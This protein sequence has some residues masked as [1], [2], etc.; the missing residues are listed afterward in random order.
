MTKPLKLRAEGADD[1]A[2]ISAALQDAIARVGEIHFSPK[3]RTLTLRFTR[4]RHEDESASQRTLTGLR[5]D[6]ILSVQSSGIDRADPDAMAVLL[7]IEF[8]PGGEPPGGHIDFVFAGG[9]RLRAHAE[10][11]DLTLADVSTARKTDKR[12]LHPLDG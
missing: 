10:C 12:P 7:A 4:F 1:L 9:G 2:V 5:A 8:A 6:G 3:A 11:I